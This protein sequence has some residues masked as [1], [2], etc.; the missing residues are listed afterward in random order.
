MDPRAG[1]RRDVRAASDADGL[2]GL[3][4]H[5]RL[6]EP[7]VQLAIP[8]DV[9]AEARR[10]AARDDLEAAAHRVAGFARR[11]DL[12]DHPRARH[13]HRRSAAPS[14][15]RWPLRVVERHRQRIGQRR[16]PIETT[17]LTISALDLSEQLPRDGADRHARGR[18]AGAGAL[19][20]VPDVV[21][22]VL[23]DA[24]EI[25][26]AGPRA[27]DDRPIDA[28]A[29]G[30]AAADSTA[31]VRC[32]FSQ[33]LFGISSAIGPPVVTPVADAAQDLRAVGLDRH[34]PAAAV[35]GLAAA[36]L[37]GDGVEVDRETRRHALRGW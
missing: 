23:D 19:E 10:H 7:A 21:V 35:A 25:G 1:Q 16:G 34:P 24:G 22:A 15:R 4:R 3:D 37:S 33:S 13:R 20:D 31:I 12:G 8:L 6:R 32:Q 27:R 26:V 17:W 28:G 30:R 36:Q 11:V 14:R 5:Q 2:D 29:S 18:F 9:A